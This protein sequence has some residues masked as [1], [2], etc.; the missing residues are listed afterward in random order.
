MANRQFSSLHSFRLPDS[1]FFSRFTPSE[2][3]TFSHP[4][5]HNPCHSERLTG[6]KN[7]ALFQNPLSYSRLFLLGLS[8]ERSTLNAVSFSPSPS[9]HSMLD[10]E[11]SMFGVQSL[12]PH[13]HI[14]SC[15]PDSSVTLLPQNDTHPHI[16]TSSTPVILSDPRER[17]M[18][19]P[20]ME[21]VFP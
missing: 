18:S 3:H 14:P 2:G 19:I 9:S 6:A 11:C 1:R 16:Q 10:V 13:S 20:S 8:S 21:F 4:S 17:R 5:A 7:L 12:N 15:H